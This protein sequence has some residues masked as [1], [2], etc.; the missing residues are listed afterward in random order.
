MNYS[1]EFRRREVVTNPTI[2]C[3]EG[4][5]RIG[6]RKYRR[7]AKQQNGKEIDRSDEE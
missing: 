1:I 2:D 7:E 5:Y 4:N 3:L 6:R